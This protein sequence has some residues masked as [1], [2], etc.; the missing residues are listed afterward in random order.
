MKTHALDG[1]FEPTSNMHTA[2]GFHRAITI[3]DNSVM[4]TGGTDSAAAWDPTRGSSRQ[5]TGL[6][7]STVELYRDDTRSWFSLMPMSDARIAHGLAR[8]P[9]GH[10]L[11]MGGDG[12][13]GI[14]LRSV[15][16]YDIARGVWTTVE[17]L[18]TPRFSHGTVVLDDGRVLVCGGN[19]LQPTGGQILDSVEIYE[20]RLAGWQT[21]A[22]MQ[23]PRMN[24]TATLLPSGKV[25]VI[26]G[27]SGNGGEPVEMSAE[28][29]DPARDVW[30]DAARLSIPRMQHTAVQLVDGTVLVAGGSSEPF[31]PGLAT[32]Q[33]YDPTEDAWRPTVDLGTGRKGHSATLLPNGHVLVAGTSSLSDPVSARTAELYDPLHAQWTPAP[34]MYEGRFEHSA[35]LMDNGRVLIAGGQRPVSHP[36][37]LDAAELFE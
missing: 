19:N 5:S 18:A 24:H 35:T 34:D 27:Y 9:S 4:V 22:P 31:M 26:G 25:L 13:N 15:E 37:Y 28:L 33:V 1:Q 30:S 10:L 32:S 2:R 21:V 3:Y 36:S 6:A 17:S 7:V 12:G 16:R 23:R 11:A 8:L 20:E 29:Y 14:S